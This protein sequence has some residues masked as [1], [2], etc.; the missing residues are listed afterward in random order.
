MIQD[1]VPDV[2]FPEQQAW[3]LRGIRCGTVQRVLFDCA[4]LWDGGMGKNDLRIYVFVGVEWLLSALGGVLSGGYAVL[5]I[6][7]GWIVGNTWEQS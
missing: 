3:T 1:G 5:R 4:V 7:G 2:P 6:G